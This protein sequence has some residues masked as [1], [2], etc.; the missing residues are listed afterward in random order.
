MGLD[1]SKGCVNFRDV[2]DWVNTIAGRVL[3]PHGRIL[4]GGKINFV[5][6]LDQI[7]GAGTIINLRRG[8]DPSDRLF[9][10]EYW[11][12]PIS[13][14]HEKYET[15]DPVVRCWLNDVFACIA[16]RASRLPILFHCTSGKDRTAVVVAA[17]LQV[18]GVMRSVIVEEYLLSDG[19][20]RR[21][22]IETAL[23]GIDDPEIYFRH[24]DLDLIRGKLLE[25][26][27]Q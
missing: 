17:L 3:L 12:F 13:N 6:S 24:V 16:K 14:D 8:P 23:D 7:G 22:W 10:A 21:E 11:H 2:G 1:Y 18:M 9:G 20:V 5:D 27:N 19:E 26:R 15:T 4:R 25:G